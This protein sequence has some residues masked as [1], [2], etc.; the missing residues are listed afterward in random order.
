M[1]NIPPFEEL[2][3]SLDDL[4]HGG[5]RGPNTGSDHAALLAASA[6]VG[7]GIEELCGYTGFPLE[8]VLPIR[9]RMLAA[10]LWSDD[11]M[12]HANW[13]DEEDGGIAFTM[14]TLVAMGMV[15]RRDEPEANPS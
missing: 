3:K 4:G 2:R 8:W 15:E 13:L 7:C 1:S 12:V 5:E 10:G 6:V 11:G 9:D 14:D